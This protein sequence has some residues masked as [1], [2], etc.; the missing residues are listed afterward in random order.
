MEYTD[1]KAMWDETMENPDTTYAFENFCEKLDNKYQ[2][3]EHNLY[4]RILWREN[5]DPEV[6]E[7]LL[8]L[9]QRFTIV[10]YIVFE[11]DTN[12]CTV[13]VARHKKWGL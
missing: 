8:D 5:Y 7:E 9:G 6:Y 10:D 3:N 11:D 12:E 2:D 13:I 1:V 4:V